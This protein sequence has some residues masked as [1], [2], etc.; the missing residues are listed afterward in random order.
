M[1]EGFRNNITS[2][3]NPSLSYFGLWI[4][5]LMLLIVLFLVLLL[6]MLKVVWLLGP[7]TLTTL[8]LIVVLM[9]VIFCCQGVG[10][11]NL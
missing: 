5:Q 8:K 6:D 11:I 3:K 4:T 9:V 1:M 2:A 10:I 7:H